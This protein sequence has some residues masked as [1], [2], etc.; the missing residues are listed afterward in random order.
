MIFSLNLTLPIWLM[1]FVL[2]S[3][4]LIYEDRGD[5]ELWKKKLFGVAENWIFSL[6]A[7][8]ALLA[9]VM[10]LIKG[11][12]KK[13]AKGDPQKEIWPLS[14]TLSF[15]FTGLLLIVS[16]AALIYNSNVEYQSF[17]GMPGLV[18]GTVFIS[19]S[20]YLVLMALFHLLFWRNDFY[21]GKP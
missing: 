2:E 4:T 15:T 21:A 20:L 5:P 6:I 13:A 14:K 19:W 18:K 16:I 9:L 10:L 3:S 12:I 7:I 1:K 11:V 17:I 8:S